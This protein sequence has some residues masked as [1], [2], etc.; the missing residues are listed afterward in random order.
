MSTA[1]LAIR[2]TA[3]DL[4][5]KQ[6]LEIRKA[7]AGLEEKVTRFGHRATEMGAKLSLGLTAPLTILGKT[8]VDA[9]SDMAESASKM[10]VVFGPV[11]GEIEAFAKNAATNLGMSKQAATE[12]AGTFG[13]L[14]S[15]L[16]LGK[17]EMADMS[18]GILQL[19]ADLAS[20]NNLSPEEVL[21]KLRAGLVGEAEPLRALGV[22]LSAAA[23]EAKAMEMGLADA[24]G[25]LSEAAK[26]QARYALIMEQT[27]LAQGDFARTSDGLANSSR[28][29]KAQM[30]DLQ[31]EMGANLLPVMLE[32]N[33][34]IRG[35]MEAFS[36]LSP[37]IKTALVAGAGFL[38]VIGPVTTAVGA[39]S[40]VL[41]TA[42]GAMK[43]AAAAQGVLNVVLAANPIGLVVVGLAALTAALVV[44]YNN[45]ED[46]RRVIDGAMSGARS[47][48]E[49]MSQG[50]RAALDWLG[51]TV[52]NVKTA[53]A[54]LPESIRSAL[55]DIRIDVGP[56]HLSGREGFWVDAPQMPQISLPSFGGGGGEQYSERT[57]KSY[58]NNAQGDADRRRDE[59]LAGLEGRQSGG[60]VVAGMPYLVGEHGPELFVPRTV[61]YVVPSRNWIGE[62]GPEAHI[63]LPAL[64]CLAMA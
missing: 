45:S 63:T 52:E 14:F 35:G 30:E 36:G 5:K 19:S 49:G 57:G 54:N 6:L 34:V 3:Q 50:A 56:F 42:M 11:S 16:G 53:L 40:M 51:S 37:E 59:W 29:A 15:A 10:Q 38:A 32:V 24:S 48:I 28:I 26:V 23:V 46:F 64:S 33:K 21:E 25:E 7:T 17:P 27:K 22:N 12:A 31:A 41:G 43:A 61:G 47:A 18:T 62:A 4:A 44:A 55:A 8:A 60:P 20:F 9:A 58:P 39:A 13:N 1:D 2:I